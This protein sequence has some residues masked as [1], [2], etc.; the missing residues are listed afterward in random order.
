[1]SLLSQD[2]LQSIVWLTAHL[3]YINWLLN[4]T[5][6]DAACIITYLPKGHSLIGSSPCGH[7]CDRGKWNRVM[8]RG[9]GFSQCLTI[10]FSMKV[11]S[12]VFKSD[13]ETLKTIDEILSLCLNHCTSLRSDSS[14]SSF[15][16][17]H[18]L[19]NQ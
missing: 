9:P 14:A 3:V 10:T 18:L 1:M 15:V 6:K 13:K 17:L 11:C 7:F 16:P 4:R 8:W 19:V 2:N 12:E 5:Y